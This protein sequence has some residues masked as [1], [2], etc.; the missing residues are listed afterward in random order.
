MTDDGTRLVKLFLHITPEEQLR[1]FE[2][3]LHDPMKRWKLTFDDFATAA[4]GTTISRRPTRWSREPRPA[5]APWHVIPAKD[6]RYGRIA[7]HSDRRPR[8]CAIGCLSPPPLD[9]A[10]EEVKAVLG[11]ARSPA[12]ADPSPPAAPSSP[13]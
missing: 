6:K 4:T 3:R 9:R 2:A 10:I 13:S 5:P 11:Q 1:R 8:P 7:L 12:L